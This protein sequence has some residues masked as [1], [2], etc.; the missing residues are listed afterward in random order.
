[1]NE[2]DTDTP[3]IGKRAGRAV[4][5]CAACVSVVVGVLASLYVAE[6]L[7]PL[8]IADLTAQLGTGRSGHF[9]CAGVRPVREWES[10][11]NDPIVRWWRRETISTLS[12]ASR[13]NA[14]SNQVHAI[15]GL[16]ATRD[17]P[18]AGRMRSV[19]LAADSPFAEWLVWG[20]FWIERDDATPFL[21]ECVKRGGYGRASAVLCLQRLSFVISP[22]TDDENELIRFWSEWWDENRPT[23]WDERFAKLLE[24]ASIVV[25]RDAAGAISLETL[26]DACER[27]PLQPVRSTIQEWDNDILESEL[28]AT[29]LVSMRVS[30]L[31]CERTGFDVSPWCFPYGFP[32]TSWRGPRS[33][34]GP[35]DYRPLPCVQAWREAIGQVQRSSESVRDRVENR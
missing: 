28:D 34:S 16:A 17:R 7:L 30:E 14:T 31:L 3:G 12:R 23:S 10:A 4:Y 19:V 13:S 20:A 32:D 11:M 33:H 18:A 5:R 29:T 1:M 35:P 25:R 26:L 24:N 9:V 6:R 27:F 8:L 15:L 2:S 21:I 22:D